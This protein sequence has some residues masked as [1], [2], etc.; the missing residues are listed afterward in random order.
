VTRPAEGEEKERPTK[1]VADEKNRKESQEGVQMGV[2]LL[3][4]DIEVRKDCTE[5]ECNKSS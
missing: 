3:S 5:R 2:V 1:H 4:E